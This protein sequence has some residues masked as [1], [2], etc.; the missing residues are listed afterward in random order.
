M[1]IV[2]PVFKENIIK[3]FFPNSSTICENCFDLIHFDVWSAPCAT[4]DQNKYFVTFIDEKSKY[5][6]LTLLPL[7][8]RVFELSQTFAAMSLLNIVLRSR[9]CKLIME[10]NTPTMSSKPSHQSKNS[11]IRQHVLI[12]LNKMGWLREKLSPYGGC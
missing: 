4:R 3:L 6:W 12:L 8:G 10:E 1:I 5:T 11:C 7:K 9:P 2:R